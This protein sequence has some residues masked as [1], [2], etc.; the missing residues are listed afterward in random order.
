MQF[1]KNLI[2]N[3]TTLL[4]FFFIT[5][6]VYALSPYISIDH[7]QFND[8]MFL[9]SIDTK[10]KSNKYIIEI[11]TTKNKYTL[12][13]KK[14]L[15]TFGNI[16]SISPPNI[17]AFD[18]SRDNSPEIFIQ[19]FDETTPIQH[20]YT[21]K[22]NTYKHLFSSTNNVLGILD[23]NNS[24]TPK[25][26][27]FSLESP[28]KSLQKHMLIND[29][30]KNI[31]FFNDE[32]PGLFCIISLIDSLC[33]QKPYDNIFTEKSSCTEIKKLDNIFN[34]KANFIFLDALFC[35]VS[36][37][38]YDLIDTLKWTLR[39]KSLNSNKIIKLNILT[40]KYSNKFLIEKINA[41]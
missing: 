12:E 1:K 5:P 15:N 33:Y 27:S 40:K 10:L 11:D 13:P 23:S 9:K 21:F 19:S 14:P 20:I 17:F 18:I 41:E 38:S 29:T 7:L 32:I 28:D 8:N 16:D 6:K 30:Y 4:L 2:F 37:S 22:Q 26:Y 24:K 34:D 35:D 25:V 36:W 3:I 31:S 39:F